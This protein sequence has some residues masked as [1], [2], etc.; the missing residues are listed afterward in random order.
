MAVVARLAIL[1]VVL[2]ACSGGSDATSPSSST[3]SPSTTSQQGA[4]VIFGNAQSFPNAVGGR[5]MDG[6][7]FLVR[8]D[9]VHHLCVTLGDTDLGCDDAGPVIGP[10]QD[11]T[12]ARFTAEVQ[13]SLLAY[14]YLPENATAAVAVFNDGRRLDNDIV[15]KN[16]PRVWALP[17]P[18]EVDI[19]GA[20]PIFYVAANGTE[21]P[22]PK[23]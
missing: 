17:L 12:T 1:A 21:T 23:I 4:A 14:G 5:L 19:N 2:S 9:P 3:S 10:N 7:P 13:G 6:R 20:P 8:H 11:P 18:R 16:A 15:S 22:A